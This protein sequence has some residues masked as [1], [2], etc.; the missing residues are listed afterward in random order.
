MAGAQGAFAPKAAR[1]LA[2][3]LPGGRRELRRVAIGMLSAAARK[4]G[5][6]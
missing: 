3:K 2:S 4:G 1:V 5:G 6:S